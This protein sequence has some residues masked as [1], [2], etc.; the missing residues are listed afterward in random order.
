MIKAM[1]VQKFNQPQW[2]GAEFQK[3]Y[4]PKTLNTCSHVLVRQDAVH[5]T[6]TPCY[7]GPFKV[8]KRNAKFFKLEHQG[9][10][11]VDRLIPYH[12]SIFD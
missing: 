12:G 10:V 2:H 4:V 5:K 7:N 11:S 6:L 3:T 8:L 1:N 9:N